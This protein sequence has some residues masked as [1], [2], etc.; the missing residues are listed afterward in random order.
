M[1]KKKIENF[2]LIQ[3]QV[4]R[5]ITYCRRKKGLL[6]KVMEM[7]LLCGQK[8]HLVIYDE[9]KEN[10]VVYRSDDQFDSS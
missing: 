6:K 10:L 9:I 3:D 7:S 1:G 5:N 8:I 4:L 2:T